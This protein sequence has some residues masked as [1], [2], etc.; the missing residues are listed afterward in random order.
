MIDVD[1]SSSVF[2][3]IAGA[4]SLSECPVVVPPEPPPVYRSTDLGGEE[5]D[6][7]FPAGAVE[8]EHGREN[9]SS[10]DV[11]KALDLPHLHGTQSYE[12]ELTPSEDGTVAAHATIHRHRIV[13]DAEGDG[14]WT[15]RT[16]ETASVF[17]ETM[18]PT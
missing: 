5:R 17:L 2:L 1:G 16:T 6:I 7:V 14:G 11:R 9:L 10:T 13:Q 18:G 12:G 15:C 3:E 4:G 8:A